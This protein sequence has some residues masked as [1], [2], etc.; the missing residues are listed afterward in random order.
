MYNFTRLSHIVDEF[1]LPAGMRVW[2]VCIHTRIRL[3]DGYMILPIYVPVGR[4][5][6]LYPSPYRVKPVGYSGFG[7]PLPS[8]D[9]I[10]SHPSAAAPPPHP[11]PC[12]VTSSLTEGVPITRMFY[13]TLTSMHYCT[14]IH[15]CK[16]DR[17]NTTIYCTLYIYTHMY[18]FDCS[19]QPPSSA[20]SYY[21][22]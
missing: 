16:F 1:I 3:P 10:G 15:S 6:I 5:I 13:T 8:L 7:Y 19:C 11:T 9:G 21:Y 2:V 4:N 14:T 20:S 18:L 12:R 22:W 17:L